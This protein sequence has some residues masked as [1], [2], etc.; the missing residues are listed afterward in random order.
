MNKLS[1]LML[2]VWIRQKNL[3]AN[4]KAAKRNRNDIFQTVKNIYIIIIIYNFIKNIVKFQ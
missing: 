4:H 3:K 1:R 2:R